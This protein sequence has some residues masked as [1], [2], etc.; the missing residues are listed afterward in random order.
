M[1]VG[2]LHGPL[3]RRR[4]EAFLKVATDGESLRLQLPLA[5]SVAP[6]PLKLLRPREGSR[7]AEARA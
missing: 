3:R 2:R 4:R 1:E 6:R 7:I 5:F